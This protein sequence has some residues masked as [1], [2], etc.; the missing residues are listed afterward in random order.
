MKRGGFEN[1][2]GWMPMVA[3]LVVAGLLLGGT[4]LIH[5]S[6]KDASLLVARGMGEAFLVAGYQA[7]GGE[8]FPPTEDVL[9]G[10]LE[11]HQEEGLRYVAAVTSEGEVLVAAGT[12]KG[13]NVE[14]GLTWSGGRARLVGRILLPRNRR[15][16]LMAQGNPGEM[17][18]VRRRLPRVVYEFEPVAAVELQQRSRNLFVLSGVFSLGLM[19]LAVALSRALQ[20]QEGLRSQLEHGRRLAA[21]GSMSAVLAHELRNPL[22][23]LKGHSQ[24]LAESVEDDPKLKGKAELVVNEAV[25]LERLMNDLL[26]FVK[27]GEL[28]RTPTHP[29]E[30]MNAAIATSGSG[31]VDVKAGELTPLPLDPS[32]LQQA[33]E[34]VLQ[35]AV[36]ASPEGAR[37]TAEVSQ[38]PDGLTYR[39][40]DLGPGIAPGE[41]E[42]IFEPFV[43]GKIRGVGLGLAITRRIVELHGGKITARNHPE[44][45]AQFELR[46]PGRGS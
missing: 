21:L 13:R 8:S 19:G 5:R 45:G 6:V 35:N 29:L 22:A 4:F 30:V 25:R 42:K 40:R 20:Q 7:L 11:E 31:R 18:R 44:G 28:H 23:S 17:E 36:Q 9:Q 3:A 32:R 38:G 33:L 2:V 16:A 43:T 10:F 41:E 12:A 14:E 26:T 39:I 1:A 37:V 24:L 15:R 46:L 27:S 34:N